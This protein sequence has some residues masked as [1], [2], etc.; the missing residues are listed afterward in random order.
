MRIL[1]S[2]KDGQE[3]PAFMINQALTVTGDFDDFDGEFLRL[4]RASGERQAEIR[5]SRGIC[6]NIYPQEDGK[7]GAGDSSSSQ[8]SHG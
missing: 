7:L 3:V 6:Q 2:V 4:W 5:P 1:D 8:A